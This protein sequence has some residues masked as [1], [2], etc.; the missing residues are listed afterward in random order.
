ML[1]AI[2]DV[3]LIPYGV[4]E[5][6]PDGIALEGFSTRTLK[7]RAAF[8]CAAI[9]RA[10]GEPLRFNNSSYDFGFAP[11]IQASASG[12]ADVVKDYLKSLC[13]PWDNL[14]IEFLD[15][16]FGFLSDLIEQRRDE[17]ERKL[18]PYAGLYGYKDWLF[19]APKPLPRAHL[20]APAEGG[21]STA[22]VLD[23]ADF[24][25]VDFAFW[26]GDRL[27]AAQSSQSALTPKKAKEQAERL[28]LA[29]V[30]V[31]A[32]GAADIASGK[33]RELFTRLL[34]P[35]SLAF[36]QGEALPLGP[37]RPSLLDE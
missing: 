23:A 26:L 2:P 37:F 25:R 17:L 3:L 9:N 28:R 8:P 19:S 4:A 31:I 1:A 29:D 13:R 24:V 6:S 21:R 10:R 32:F 7:L 5:W 14:S 33:A 34:G 12:E 16:Y 27:V 18:A 22:V 11:S 30:E 35:T 20:H 15:A 36:W